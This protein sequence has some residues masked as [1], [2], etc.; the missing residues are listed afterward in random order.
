M[1]IHQSKVI[2]LFVEGYTEIDFYKALVA[3]IRTLH[4]KEFCCN[5]EYKNMKGVGN[6]K[7]DALRKLGEVKR[8]YPE[9]DIYAF[10]C[11]DTDVFHLSKKPPVDMKKVR[12]QLITNGAKK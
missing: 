8:K 5:I 6:Y 10:L 3:D 2:I 7:N 11:Y 12:K 4:D 1:L 9:S